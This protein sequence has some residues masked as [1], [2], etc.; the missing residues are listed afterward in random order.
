LAWLFGA[1]CPERRMGA[2]G[3]MPEVNLEAMQG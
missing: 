3:V 2:A 1:V